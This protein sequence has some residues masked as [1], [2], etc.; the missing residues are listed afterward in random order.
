M[1]STNFAMM[2]RVQGKVSVEQVMT[3]LSRVRV[4]HPA[5][6]PAAGGAGSEAFFPLNVR[7]D[8]GDCDWIEVAQAELGASFPGHPGPF[9][10]F[11]LL[12]R[13]S[14][15]GG[16]EGFD[17]VAAFHHGICDGMSGMFVLRDVL[18]ALGDPQLELA[19]L[20]APPPTVT[21]IPASALSNPE[22]QRKIWL[23]VAVL[24]GQV[25]FEKVRRRLSPGKRTKTPAAQ[26]T[27]A[28]N[29]LAER[30]FVILP[31]QL[32]A[33]QTT[34]LLARCKKEQVSVH[35]AVCVAWLRA[36]TGGATSSHIGTVSSPVN[37]RERL[38]PPV[39]DTSGLFLATVETSVDCGPERDFWDAARE[40]KQKLEQDS[41]NETLFFNPLLFSKIFTPQ[42]APA[43]IGILVEMLFSR[44]VKYDFSITNLGRIP[45]AERSGALQVEAFYGP[46]VN[47]SPY[48]R[49]VGVS[50]VAGQM[51]LAFIFRRS[52]LE[53]ADGKQLMERAIGMLT[54]VG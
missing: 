15:P 50:T 1:L 31:E 23:T 36:F 9:A 41:R 17:L 13:P 30:Q 20:P 40:F 37:L 38:S 49:T 51:S 11:T 22:L 7:A 26:E 48:E 44:P 52:M 39:G 43:D 28:E 2:V 8:C 21:L 5:L 33:A 18:Q 10:R 34:A 54:A 3:A 53:P 29:P 32:S 16:A 25:L 24:R 4:R 42:I 14:P 35:A 6:V 47:A 45:I 27:P 12:R 46:L 19:P